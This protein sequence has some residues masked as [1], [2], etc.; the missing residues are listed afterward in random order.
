MTMSTIGQRVYGPRGANERPALRPGWG[1]LALAAAMAAAVPAEVLA[2]NNGPA[3]VTTYGDVWRYEGPLGGAILGDGSVDATTQSWFRDVASGGQRAYAPTTPYDGYDTPAYAGTGTGRVDFS[4]LPNFPRLNQGIEFWTQERGMPP[5][6]QDVNLLRFNGHVTTG[7]TL[8][9]V[10]RT[11]DEI[12]LGTITFRNGSWYG[13]SPSFDAGGGPLYPTSS[14]YFD[15]T[16]VASPW[17]GTPT[18][19][20]PLRHIFYGRLDLITTVGANTPDY[21]E[22]R[23]AMFGEPSFASSVLAVDEGVTGTVELWG[24]IGSLIPTEFRNPSAGVSIL[25]SIP[26]TPVP[27]PATMALMLAG[28]AVVGG[29][30]QRRRSARIDG[31]A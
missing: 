14:F 8:D 3:T 22:L 12:R 27:E 1:V 20:N 25:S 26:V 15:V 9:P 16:A 28:L 24:R 6:P 23:D 11:S 4:T 2:Q 30:A 10:T 7:V 21:L 18:L 31:A 19:T 17:I 5:R 29:A 13:G